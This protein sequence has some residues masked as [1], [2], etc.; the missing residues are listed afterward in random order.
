MTKWEPGKKVEEAYSEANFAKNR[1]KERKDVLYQ[2]YSQADTER[3][4][5][6]KQM[7]DNFYRD[8]ND[9]RFEIWYQPSM[10]QRPTSWSVQRDLSGGEEGIMRLFRHLNLYRFLKETA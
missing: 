7:E 8:L 2:I 4:V 1:I 10:I 5:E 9:N 3:I 6:E